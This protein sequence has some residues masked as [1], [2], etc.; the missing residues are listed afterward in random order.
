MKTVSGEFYAGHKAAE[1]PR[2]A[3]IEGRRLEVREVLDRR[4]MLDP[5]TGKVTDLFRCR[6]EDDRVV[7]VA[8]SSP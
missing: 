8:A 4:R 7:D 2:F 1:T 6:L 5:K 3:V